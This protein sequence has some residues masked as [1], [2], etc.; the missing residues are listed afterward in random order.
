MH[1]RKMLGCP[2]CQISMPL[3]MLNISA[4]KYKD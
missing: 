2:T 4:A 3:L 1:M